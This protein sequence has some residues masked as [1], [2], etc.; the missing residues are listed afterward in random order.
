M[1]S[2]AVTLH[3]TETRVLQPVGGCSPQKDERRASSRT[4]TIYKIA[5]VMT[6]IDSGLCR[7]QNISDE[8]LMLFTSLELD[9]GE[10]INVAMSD[11]A[12]MQGTVVWTDG[13]RTGIRFLQPID[14]AAFLQGL[15]AEQREG[16]RRAP[17][18]PV[19][20]IG[21]A[22]TELGTQVVRVINISQHGMR[23]AHD[24]SFHPGLVVQVSLENGL[25]RRGVVRWSEE[26]TAGLK[27][28]E[29]I[30]HQQ[31]GSSISI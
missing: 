6:P 1:R 19:S 18:L 31:L 16:H 7:V 29:P 21:M 2:L 5:R 30:A 27:L 8:G 20:T 26:G 22:T 11:Q 15:S 23:V 3:E 17:R 13:I 25:E 10:V 9:V 14:S 24:G 12:G 4:R 28:I